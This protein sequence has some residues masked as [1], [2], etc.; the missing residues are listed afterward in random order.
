[1]LSLLVGT[2]LG[3]VKARS[4]S[5]TGCLEP[6]QTGLDNFWQFSKGMLIE[7]APEVI[8]GELINV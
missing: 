5:T 4:L 6:S 7:E 1:M 2:A 8:S 3:S